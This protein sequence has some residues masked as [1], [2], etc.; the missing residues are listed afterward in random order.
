MAEKDTIER[1]WLKFAQ[2]FS[3]MD[4]NTEARRMFYSGAIAV[5]SMAY[6]ASQGGQDQVRGLFGRL[7]HE[8]DAYFAEERRRNELESRRLIMPH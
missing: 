1:E 3:G 6:V 5:V 4:E 2:H 8:I 7:R